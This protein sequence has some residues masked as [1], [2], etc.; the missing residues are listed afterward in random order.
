M[1]RSKRARLW[2]GLLLLPLLALLMGARQVPLVDPD[3]IAVPAGL[4]EAR[5]AKAIKAALVGRTWVIS[6]EQPG[7]I[8]ATLNLRTHMA[9]I[10]IPFDTKQVAVRYLDSSELMYG[11]KKGVKV[12]HRNYLSWIQ[13]LVGDISRNMILAGE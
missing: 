1:I 12:I 4:T 6:E 5:V 8:I 7:K 2:S 3:P 10:E 13:N 9:K 11:E